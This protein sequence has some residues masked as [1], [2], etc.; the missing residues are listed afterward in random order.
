MAAANSSPARQWGKA[1]LGLLGTSF[2]ALV[3]A[4]A[5]TSAAGHNST[6]PAGVPSREDGIVDVVTTTPIVT[7]LARHVAG[8][9]AR[10]T[11]L[12]PSNADPHTHELTLR[13]VRNIANADIAFSNG[14]LLEPQPVLRSLHNSSLPGTPVV[15]VA[16]QATTRG[17]TVVPLVENLALDTVWL[18]LRSV[19][20]KGPAGD[21]AS[22]GSTP[23]ASPDG[24]VQLAVT[25]VDGP[26][27]AAAYV[28]GTFGNPEI[29]FNSGD[30]FDASRGYEGDSTT[31]PVDAHTHMSWAFSQPG[32]YRVHFKASASGGA[33]QLPSPVA[34]QTV[35]F[36]VG[37]PPEEA[38]QG[39][40]S[41]GEKP[42]YLDHG[43]VDVAVGVDKKTISLRGDRKDTPA[44]K[45]VVVVPAKSL[46]QIPPS[47]DYR[48]LGNPGSETYMLPQAVLGKHVHG[49]LDPHLWHNVRNVMAMVK[50]IRDE[51]IA[52]D[53]EGTR[54]YRRN[55][56]SYLERLRRLD[57]DM[58]RAVDAVPQERRQL[59]TA[60]D[61]YAYLADA[62]GMKIGGFVSPN[63]A[64]EPSARDV[65]ALTRTLENLKVP[66]VFLEPSL[67]GQA[68]DLKQI[69]EN[70]GI[71]V[72]TIRGDAFDPE[73]GDYEEL[74]RANARNFTE[75][76]G[77]GAEPA[78][79]SSQGRKE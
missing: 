62:Y 57:E 24:E 66:A 78:K 60:H 64:V 16:E 8:D 30:G 74:M 49:E 40:L 19:S 47:A 23:P 32:V 51:L 76:L 6:G 67:A 10:V 79:G 52:V 27:N 25:G 71:R 14:L 61:G 56:E 20:G 73:V 11:G 69:A 72:C 12:I 9:R 5:P 41:A 70:L 63:P 37:V 38:A 26:G 21:S 42:E 31:L 77:T 39:M 34:E 55:T 54:E 17:A 22:S 15:S 45:A 1:A 50:V 75:C 3:A 28:T 13:D 53:P 33:G 48:F 58:Q 43:H 68:R 36:A 35:T 2:L 59:V 18:G 29:F 46:Q 7:D 65:I 4:C 44:D